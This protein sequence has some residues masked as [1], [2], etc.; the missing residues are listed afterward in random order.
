M[1]Q[2][3]RRDILR[4]G[5]GSAQLALLGGV[6][7]LKSS[8]ARAALGPGPKKLLTVYV[9]GGWHPWTFF[10]PLT[11]AEIEA[12]VPPRNG[13]V[14]GE[15][16]WFGS[17]EVTNLDGSGDATSDEGIPRLRTSQ[18]WDEAR[19]SDPPRGASSNGW[20]WKEYR[21]WEKAVV[22][23]GVDMGTASHESGLI[24]AMCGVPGS[25]YRSP[26]LHARIAATLFD[27]YGE[28]RPL[29]AVAI[30]N[31][32]VP[33]HLDLGPPGTATVMRSLSSLEQTFTD[34]IDRAWSGLRARSSRPQVAFDGAPIATP[35]DTTEM[36][37]F[38]LRRT[39][40]LRG[41]VNAPTDA[42][43]ES[44][45]D[46][47]VGVS[48]RLA[49]D[50]VGMLD[51]TPAWEHQP[52]PYW[53]GGNAPWGVRMGPHSRDGGST[54]AS[55]F[56]LALKMLKSDLCSA[57]SLEARGVGGFHFDT[58]SGSGHEVQCLQVRAVLDVVGRLLGEMRATP[59][60]G[61]SNLLDD[62][63]V[64]V[65]SEF[66]RTWPK[67]GV[68]DHW[69]FTS[70]ILAGGNIRP[71]Q[72]IG[73]YRFGGTS[74]TGAEVDMRLEGGEDARLAPRSADVVQTAL[75]VMG[76]ADQTLPGGSAEIIGVRA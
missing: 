71:N 76:I 38:A 9:P 59:T 63:L 68:C 65:Q 58:H 26:A 41:V 64:I 1:A 43:Y 39:R 52:E 33:A 56:N 19:L 10:C 47:Y 30:G 60:S 12:H 28:S 67:G 62:T 34:R 73:A 22:L 17:A 3:T 32:P 50:V 6:G 55:S 75:Q 66:A 7:L 40:A 48:K 4:L 23:H 70:V 21:L 27:T 2:K 57:V 31:G 72:M 37:E 18:P 42:F 53:T 54:W 11:P 61:G 16:A 25:R 8:S 51:G 13:D 69:P 46:M 74:P 35:L 29:G 5:L 36:D 14:Q 44:I 15:P 20:A 49:L 45:H 24:S